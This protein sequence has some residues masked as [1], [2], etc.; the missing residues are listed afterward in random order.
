[1]LV[2]MAQL[3]CIERIDGVPVAFSQGTKAVR[4]GEGTI[5]MRRVAVTVANV[6]VGNKDLNS[7]L[8]SLEVIAESMLGVNAGA[9][10]DQLIQADNARSLDIARSFSLMKRGWVIASDFH[11]TSKSELLTSLKPKAPKDETGSR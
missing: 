5:L 2:Q 9:L 11:V 1:M 3:K 6:D 4:S 8:D 7:Y 10:A